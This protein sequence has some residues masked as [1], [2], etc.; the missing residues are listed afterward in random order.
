MQAP[1]EVYRVRDYW[2]EGRPRHFADADAAAK[3]AGEVRSRRD[4][5]SPGRLEIKPLLIR[6]EKDLLSAL[7]GAAGW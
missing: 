4:T 3:Y 2:A 5:S 7:D 6:S 1:V